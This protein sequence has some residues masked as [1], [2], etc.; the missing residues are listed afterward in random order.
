MKPGAMKPGAMKIEPAA[1]AYCTFIE[2]LRRETLDELAPLCHPEVRF[3][4]PFNDFTGVSAFRAVLEQMFDDLAEPR[5]EV[6]DLAIS[7]PV[8]Y[9]RW[10]FTFRMRAG[11]KPW[12]IEGM[13][14]VHFDR[15][16]LVTAHLDH[17][18]SGAQFY[19]KLP[20]VGW[21]IAL[22]RRRLALRL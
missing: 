15:T 10:D 21:L 3:R 8:A 19:G 20:V 11:G 1:R 16:G 17:W 13:S 7:G 4:D 14:E 22:I 5:F 6:T 9:I 18:D 2:T 12:L